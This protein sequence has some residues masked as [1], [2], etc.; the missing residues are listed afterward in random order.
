MSNDLENVLVVESLIDLEKASSP[1]NVVLIGPTFKTLNKFPAAAASNS[2]IVFNNIVAPSLTTVMKRC[3]RIEMEV[4]VTVTCTGA[5]GTVAATDA[6]FNAYNGIV[7]AGFGGPVALTSSAANICLRAFPLSGVISSADIRIN[8]GATN[9]ALASY[10]QIYPFLQGDDDIKRYASECP[11]QADNSAV[12]ENALATSPFKGVNANSATQSRGSFLAELTEAAGAPLVRKYTVRWTEE[13][14]ISPFLTGRDMETDVGLVNVNN[15]TVTLRLGDLTA[16]FSGI[17]STGTIAVSISTP[18]SLLIEFDTQNTIFQQRSPTNAVYPYKQLQ[19]YQQ[20]IGSA[21]SGELPLTA[22]RLPCQPSKIY[23][24]I[25]PAARSINVSDHFLRISNI[26]VNFN[27]KN[28]LLNGMNESS[29]YTMSAFNS[30]SERGGFMSWNQ[31]RYGCG[32]LIVIDVQRDLSVEEGSQSGSMNN[33]ST[34]QITIKYN[35]NNLL[36]ANNN[37]TNVA[38]YN[39]YQVIVNPGKLYLSPSQGEFV[40]QGP[41]PAVVLGLIADE[42]T[43]KIPEDS[44]QKNG[45]VDGLGFSSLVQKGLKLAYDNRDAIYGAAKPHLKKLMGGAV[46]AGAM[47]GGAVHRRA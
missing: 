33:F 25:A 4:I 12:Y 20:A 11:L 9:C 6:Q 41:A 10:N 47:S 44:L 27:N 42:D 31:W 21:M 23:V 39:A 35:N 38:L 19:T 24:F 8:G 34:L 14:I 36:Y 29:L 22:L 13:L 3:L 17:F 18:P 45:D 43:T 15:L 40:V 28:S 2:Q 7:G 16:M 30:A 37:T 46:S 32:S 26:S 5:A 1:S